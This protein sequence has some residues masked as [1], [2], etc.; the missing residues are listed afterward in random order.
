MLTVTRR[1]ALRT[2][3]ATLGALAS[4]L[5][6]ASPVVASEAGLQFE[7]YKD[8]R[9]RFRWRLKSGNGQVVATAGDSYKSKAGCRDG[10]D[11]VMRGAATASIEDLT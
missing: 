4:G 7:L 6:I 5:A 3:T 8:F 1:A 2:A 11:L 9:G 10:I